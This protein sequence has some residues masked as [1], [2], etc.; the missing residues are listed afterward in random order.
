M[1]N[2]WKKFDEKM[3]KRQNFNLQRNKF[4]K[5]LRLEAKSLTLTTE[6]CMRITFA[7]LAFADTHFSCVSSSFF[8]WLNLPDHENQ[9]NLFW[10]VA[11]FWNINWIQSDFH[12][13][14]RLYPRKKIAK[15]KLFNSTLSYFST[16]FLFLFFAV[17]ENYNAWEALVVGCNQ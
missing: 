15:E 9:N 13:F 16:F 10:T 3:L 2:W 12:S 1:N 5:A 7:M 6:I 17:M 11:F 14:S 4:I 8:F